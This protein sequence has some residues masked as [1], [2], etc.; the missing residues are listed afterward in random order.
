MLEIGVSQEIDFG[1]IQSQFG[2]LKM[3]KRSKLLDLF[4]NLR[5]N[6]E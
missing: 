6:Q 4:K 3:V 5:K 1:V 2:F